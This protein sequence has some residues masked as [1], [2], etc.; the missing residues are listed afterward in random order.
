MLLQ[1]GLWSAL[2]QVIRFFSRIIAYH[3]WTAS[4]SYFCAQVEQKGQLY[5]YGRRRQGEQCLLPFGGGLLV[6]PVRAVNS[7]V[8]R[9]GGILRRCHGSDLPMTDRPRLCRVMCWLRLK[10]WSMSHDATLLP[11]SA[12]V[13]VYERRACVH[14]CMSVRVRMSVCGGHALQYRVCWLTMMIDESDTFLR[15][16]C[17]LKIKWRFPRYRQRW[18]GTW[19][20]MRWPN[21]LPSTK[22]SWCNFY[23]YSYS[24]FQASIMQRG[25]L[26]VWSF[27]KQHEYYRKDFLGYRH[28]R[29]CIYKHD[30]FLLFTAPT[31]DVDWMNNACFASCSTDTTILVCKLGTPNPVKKFQ[32]HQVRPL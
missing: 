11:W 13:A 6:P 24:W 28:T 5:P 27:D 23:L 19:L 30:C 14:V 18:S 15:L 2:G 22:V 17:K 26:D 9:K 21:V 1:I 10:R 32:G 12:C 16:I 29:T 25:H 4:G 7:V 3:P 8:L 20:P 31:L